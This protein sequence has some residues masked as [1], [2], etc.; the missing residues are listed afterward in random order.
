MTTADTSDERKDT[1]MVKTK[2]KVSDTAAAV[3]P[4]IERAMSDEKLRQDVMEA[5]ATAKQIYTELVGGRGVTTIASRVATDEDLQAQLRKS[6][7]DLR[8]A[9]KRLQGKD[10]HKARNTT[11]LLAGITL[12]ILFN[13]V[14]GPDTRRWLKE[15]I[16]G[17]SDDF[18]SSYESETSTATNGA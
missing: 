3:K 16:T 17:G 11:L 2:D 10:E 18:G 1:G 4:Y 5:V 14:T 13:P 15:V 6:V 12:G 7:E 8:Q 9:A